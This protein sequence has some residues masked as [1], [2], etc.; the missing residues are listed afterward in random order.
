MQSLSDIIRKFQPSLFW[1]TR[2]LPRAN[3]EALYTLFAFCKHIG[4]IV[5]SSMTEAEKSE[6]LHS[7]R[8]ELDNIYDKNVPATNIGRRI[9][10]NCIRFDL[11]KAL[12]LQILEGA[13]LD[14]VK[15]MLAP[16]DDD[17]EKYI[18]GIAVVPL[19]LVLMIVTPVHPYANQ[20][21]AKN[22]GW[23]ASLTYILRDIKDDAKRGR[24]YI[25]ER[26]LSEAGIT[27]HSPQN[28]VEDKNLIIA[29]AALAAK[30]MSGYN[31]AERLLSKMNKSDTRIL[32][33]FMNT[34]IA[35][36][37]QMQNRGWEIISPK[38]KLKF[39]RR[40]TI[41]YRTLFK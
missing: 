9:Y 26:F 1:C 23:A 4:S 36:F 38:P 5:R 35:L 17:F 28:I 41:L 30:V 15:P 12:W 18:Y 24:I 14:A 34:G 27:K 13:E 3:R 20:E 11:P 32:R 7:W 25:P 6:L 21:L 29:R 39:F 37:M 10:K 33:F 2:S 16:S 22:L 40:L 19:H 8:E 31:K